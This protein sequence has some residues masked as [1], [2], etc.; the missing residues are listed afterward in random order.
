MSLKKTIVILFYISNFAL[1]QYNLNY[2]L[3]KA[4]S[5]SPLLKEFSNLSSIN[6]LQNKLDKAQNSAFQVSLSSNLLFSPFFNN[7]GVFFTP[8]PGPNAIGYDVATTN[9]GLYSAQI[10]VGKNIFNSG[11]LDILNRQR[12]IQGKSYENKSFMERHNIEKQVTDQ[13][14]N[15]L[16]YLLLYNLSKN[17]ENNLNKQ[18]IITENLVEKGFSKASDYLQLKIEVKTQL[19]DIQQEWQNY[20]SGI[21]QL[22]SLCGIKD[23]ES[24]RIDTVWLNM[25][26]TNMVSNFL[27][28]FHY[29]SL[30]AIIQ[31]SVF[32]TK[33]QPQISVFFNAGLNAV[34]L[35]NIQRKFGVSAGINF[36]LPILDGGQKNI[37]RQQT[38]ISETSIYDY[39]NYME[40]SIFAKRKDSENK[41]ILLKKNLVSQKEQILDYNNLL[42]ISKDQLEK[43]DLSMIEYLTLLRN[44]ISLQKNEITTE[45]NYQLEI[46]NYN[47]W[48]W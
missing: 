23:T 1:A 27:N 44:F 7:N 20:K 32:E 10:N 38:A 13:Y 17:I 22:N 34:E 30:N 46:S 14:L 2:F 43:G 25:Q 26:Q 19:M 40:K 24:V 11:I 41:I 4:V 9:G 18:L 6:T 8:N 16:Q 12:L 3:N 45:I 21:S 42:I 36:S 5:N 47:Y 35:N 29:D 33:Y 15:T 28:Q 37:T 39:K 48:N 31:Q